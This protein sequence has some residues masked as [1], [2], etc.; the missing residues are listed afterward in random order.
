MKDKAS[1]HL[2]GTVL[3]QPQA[4]RAAGG[5]ELGG[6]R[7]KL[8]VVLPAFDGGRD[9]EMEFEVEAWG[10]SRE[11]AEALRVGQQVCCIG[12]MVRRKMLSPQGGYLTRKDGSFVW[13]TDYRAFS[14][15]VAPQRRTGAVAMPQ[16][17]EPQQPRPRYTEGT[18]AM[19]SRSDAVR[20]PAPPQVVEED[21]DIPF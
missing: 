17:R 21:N 14:V 15:T 9:N 1:F 3:T 13:V 2:Q 6:V 20:H 19:G 12:N 5:R 16:R 10:N 11:D 8:R 18:G 7:F 4:I